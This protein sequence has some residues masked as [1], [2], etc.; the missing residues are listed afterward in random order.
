M[1]YDYWMSKHNRNSYNNAGAKI[2]SYVHYDKAYDNAFWNGS[3]MTYGDGS[4][5]YFDALTSIDVAGHEIGHAVC[6][7]TAGLVYS[8]ESGAMNEGFSDIWGACIEAFGKNGGTANAN[9]WLIGE[10]IERRAGHAALRSMSNPN[11]EGQPDTYLG[12]SWYSGSGDNGGVHYNSG[13][14]NH[15]FYRLSVGGSGT[16]D[17]GTAFNVS[18]IGIDKAAQIAYRLE[19][20][21]LSSNSNYQAA[22]NF[23]ATAAADL[24]GAGSAEEVATIEAF[25]AVG[26]TVAGSGGGGGTGGGGG[27]EVC[28]SATGISV[29]RRKWKYYTVSVPAGATNLSV[30]TSGGSGDADLYVRFG[31]NPTKTSYAAKSENANNNESVSIN[32][33]SAGTWNIGIYGYASSSGIS[34]EACTTGGSLMGF[35]GDKLKF[36][37]DADGAVEM[38]VYPNPANETLNIDL[39]INIAEGS[40]VKIVSVTGQELMSFDADQL[41]GGIDVTSLP[42]GVYTVTAYDGK[43][44]VTE[45]FVKQ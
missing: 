12:T 37:S 27:A 40:K 38:K 17:N 9:T 43:S 31:A 29:S 20:V 28:S 13:V 44:K 21:Y 1:T 5:T 32:N 25:K 33:P 6:E 35:A 16:N 19:S 42:K 2:K 45:R 7:Y 18:A 3:V 15:W 22:A 14:L 4:D 39:G 26:L 11:S 30:S 24:Y 34:L 10:D 8:Y 36:D 23:G 41:K